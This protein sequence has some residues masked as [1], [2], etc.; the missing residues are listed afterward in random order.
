M[1]ARWT[2]SGSSVDPA[3][4]TTGSKGMV[5]DFDELVA[6]RARAR[7]RVVLC[8]GCFDVIHVGHIRHLVAARSHG[9]ALLV[10]VT[11]DRNVGKGPTRP[12]FPEAIRA[13][14]LAS[15]RSVDAV[16]INPWPSAVP[17]LDR[18]RPDV[19]AK[20]SEYRDLS[21]GMHPGFDDERR[22]AEK[23]GIHM[24]FTEELTYSST[25]IL[26]GQTMAPEDV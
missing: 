3:A 13:E 8:H 6:L 4:E 2:A 21:E 25:A 23:L 19:F 16:A 7:G 20:G 24:V 14:V 15:M 12:V 22:L 11:A 5:C 1:T 18:I 9:D 26:D 10:T 17:L